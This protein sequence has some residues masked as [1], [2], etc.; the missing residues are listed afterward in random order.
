MSLKLQFFICLTALA[1]AT[2]FSSC[3]PAVDRQF[4]DTI[5]QSTQQADSS[6][7]ALA[8]LQ[9]RMSALASLIKAAPEDV[10]KA[11]PQRLDELAMA[12][13][14]Y[15]QK[16]AVNLEP[17]QQEIANGK[18]VSEDYA[19]GKI[20]LEDAR[21]QFEQTKAQMQVINELQTEFQATYEQFDRE[22]KAIAKDALAKT[23]ATSENK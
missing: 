5:Q 7:A 6:M 9:T 11:A 20:T 12:A 10:R 8:D 22:F 17:F 16:I 4:V 19:V 15:G 23:G 3:K 1:I 14:E 2:G 13:E 21:K 18:K